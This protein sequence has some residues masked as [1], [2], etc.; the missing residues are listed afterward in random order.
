MEVL[1]LSESRV[2]ALERELHEARAVVDLLSVENEGP[3][4]VQAKAAA[5]THAQPRQVRSTSLRYVDGYGG[6]APLESWTRRYDCFNA[7]A[8]LTPRQVP[9]DGDAGWGSGETR[10][11]VVEQTRAEM[12]KQFAKLRLMWEDEL[13][14][15][16]SYVPSD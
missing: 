7:F 15:S 5:R 8:S 6:L 2:A 12:R 14:V 9:S 3:A 11:E 13:R 16:Q 1:N 10:E 4:R